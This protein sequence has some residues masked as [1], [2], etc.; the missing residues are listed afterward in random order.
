MSKPVTNNEVTF[1]SDVQ[2][3][4]TTDTQG[5]ITYA[6]D[7]FCNVAGFTREEL[8]GQNHN[9]VRHPDMPKAAF[10]DLWS[11]L[12]K[13]HSWRGMVKNRCKD[14]SY[15][16]VDAF[17][18]PL[19]D[20]NN[21]V[22]YQS[23]RCCPDRTMV[24]KAEALYRDINAGKLPSEF[25][26]NIALKRILAAITIVLSAG[27]LAWQA[28]MT[29]A[30]T[31]LISSV[32][33]LVIFSE[34]LIVLPTQINKVK[35]RYDS[36]SRWIFSGYGIAALL[37]YP[38]VMMQAKVRTI[39]GRSRDSG[40]TLLQHAQELQQ[41]SD[42]TL[43]GLFEENNQLD[44]LATAITEMTATVEDVSR[45]TSEAHDKVQLINEE[46]DQ[47]ISI[48]TG[49]QDKINHL[50]GEV[51]KAA[52]TADDLVEDVGSISA[53]MTE[54]QGI[55]DQ[56]NLLALNAAIEAARAGEQGRGFAV[57]ADEVRT[58]A[59]RTQ[60]ATEQ[61]Q[62]SVVELQN[63][64]QQWSKVM[65]ASKSEAESCVE[66]STLAK[67]SMTNIN[68]MIDDMTGLTATIA[69]ATEEQTAVA[70]EINTNVHKIDEISKDN[71][72]AAEQVNG[73]GIEVNQ[74]ARILESLSST[75]R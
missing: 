47:A 22:G 33:L 24:N 18:T 20:G 39:L 27:L 55:A 9:I 34:E 49:S 40:N 29:A 52:N 67:N 69:T 12:K 48:I 68:Q 58:L 75:F 13:G 51:E 73:T 57:V 2:L 17:V 56:T 35:E 60:S 25:Q 50:S 3:V 5:V 72:A 53:I 41:V 26:S 10:A 74:G 1:S 59:S 38:F 63:T 66:E 46:C 28:S 43:S 15:Y 8:V 36:P 31:L 11:K 4:S 64:L 71:T 62:S 32:I 42:K 16:W 23:V 19:Y 6:N 45:S 37:E 54:I 70:N 14:G 61:I 7:A 21:V 44:Q 30:L 65:L